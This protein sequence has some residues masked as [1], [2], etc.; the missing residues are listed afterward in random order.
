MCSVQY[1]LHQFS[2]SISAPLKHFMKILKTFNKS[3]LFYMTFLS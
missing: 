2:F 3:F 1:N